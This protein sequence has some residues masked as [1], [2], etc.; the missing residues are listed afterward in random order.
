MIKIPFQNK[1]LRKQW[2]IKLFKRVLS[3]VVW[4]AWTPWR[5]ISLFK[6]FFH[7]LL[8]KKAQIKTKYGC[9]VKTEVIKNM[10]DEIS[11]CF[12]SFITLYKTIFKTLKEKIYQEAF[13][14]KAGCTAVRAERIRRS[15]ALQWLE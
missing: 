11:V 15:R 10:N 7:K 9:D 12:N 14:A 1:Q 3:T 8:L 2:K 13:K 5:K 6:S 4:S